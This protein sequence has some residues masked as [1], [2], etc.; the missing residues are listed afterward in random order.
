MRSQGGTE[1]SFASGSIVHLFVPSGF[2]APGTVISAEELLR[3]PVLQNELG[4]EHNVPHRA[5]YPRSGLQSPPGSTS[6][7][8]SYAKWFSQ[9]RFIDALI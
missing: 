8:Y 5:F 4:D 9:N 6:P 7:G 3:V 2:P 1:W